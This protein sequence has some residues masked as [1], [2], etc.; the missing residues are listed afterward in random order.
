M[1]LAIFF[2]SLALA[3][4]TTVWDRD[5][6]RFAT[7]ALE[8]TRTGNLLVPT[9]N[10]ELRAQKPILPYW[11][12]AASMR[13]AGATATAARLGSCLGLALAAAFTGWLGW[14]LVSPRAGLL[15]A[16][17]LATTPLALLEGAAATADALLLAFVTGAVAVGVLSGS[18]LGLSLLLGLALLTKGP[19]G[20]VLP[21]L[22][23]AFARPAEKRRLF[24]ASILGLAIFALWFVP[25][26]QATQGRFLAIGLGHEVVTRVAQPLEGHGGRFLLSLPYYVPVVLV[27]F[28]PFTLYLPAALAALRG[29][30]QR[31]LLLAWIAVPFVLFTLVATKLPHYVLPIWPAFA[32]AV[33]AL[34]DR[35]R[36][37]ELSPDDRRWLRRGLFLYL[38]LAALAVAVLGVLAWHLPWPGLAAPLVTLGGLGAASALTASILHVRGRFTR[39]AHVLVAGSAS[40][41]LVAGL[42]LGPRVEVLKPVP[43]LVAAIRRA[44]PEAP[45]TAT[46][47]FGEPSL[48]FLLGG[49]PLKHLQTRAQAEAWLGGPGP[50]L[51][52]TTRALALPSARE[53]ASAAGP[54]LS[55]GE[56]VE[57]VALVRDP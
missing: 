16:A 12:M 3:S 31:R 24:I 30:A 18:W 13:V 11:V 1:V 37:G 2:L 42:W 38:P 46:F 39:A 23:L 36:R 9:L 35:E 43:R 27:G 33:A 57:L 10:G 49:Q 54:N 5:E 50:R 6:A 44:V 29:S 20:L 25:A 26:N 21:I 28:L 22:I 40:M 47:G 56:W 53:V 52:V 41:A 17:I 48:G 45:P 19:V 4:G 7:A 32:L 34:L 14:R 55:K 51:L 8:M 15:A